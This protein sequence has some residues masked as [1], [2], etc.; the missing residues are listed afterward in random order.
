MFDNVF[1]IIQIGSHKTFFYVIF[2]K[3]II[4]IGWQYVNLLAKRLKDIHI[5]QKW[6]F[7]WNNG[8]FWLF[9]Y[10][11]FLYVSRETI[12]CPHLFHVEQ[13]PLFWAGFRLFFRGFWAI[14]NCFYRFVSWISVL[15][16]CKFHGTILWITFG[17]FG[18]GIYPDFLG[19]I[20]TNNIM[21]RR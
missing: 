21:K 13:K 1:N 14:F 20:A 18:Q 6:R 8:I 12:S 9:W 11:L 15:S 7:T 2:L 17:F 10:E 5:L 3:N 19:I 4:T 16:P